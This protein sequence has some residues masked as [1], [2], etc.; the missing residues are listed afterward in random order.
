MASATGT[1]AR[2]TTGVSVWWRRRVGL[3]LALLVALATVHA[4]TP[5]GADEPQPQRWSAVPALGFGA[6][7]GLFAGGMLVHYPPPRIGTRG[8]VLPVV[9]LVTV[10]GQYQ[11]FFV[12]DV[13]TAG[14]AWH[15]EG[16][17]AAQSWPADA[18]TR[19][20]GRSQRAVGY[21]AD[22]VDTE[23]SAQRRVGP[24]F[25]AG[26]Q[27]RVAWEDVTWD[28]GM[29]FGGLRGARGGLIVGL[30]VSVGY[31]TR[32]RPNGPTEG[33]YLTVR[34][35]VHDAWTG[36]D[37]DFGVILVEARRYQRIAR[38]T[39]LAVAGDLRRI[40][41]SAPFREWSS[42]DGTG[43]LRGIENGLYRDLALI[44]LQSEVRHDL[45][46]RWGAVAF[47]DAAR[48]APSVKGLRP[49]GLRA[50]VGVGVRFAINPATRFALRADLSWVDGG[51]GLVLLAGD[52][53]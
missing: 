3:R 12:P 38:G 17:F 35:D 33:T 25:F 40:G 24:G 21:R 26:P 15:L 11:V 49:G 47:V 43:Q 44:S 46:R 18:Y 30:G 48:V 5:V 37:F 27:I 20:N 13:Y 32:D 7:T 10:K 53:F 14:N 51:P 45:G 39:V 16:A 4:A 19:G 52:A 1:T 6:E 36:S 23:I 41:A 28:G 22:G 31:D 42:P 8:S 2:G 34:G 29:R 50:A 9:A